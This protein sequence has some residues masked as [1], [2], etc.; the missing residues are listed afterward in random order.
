MTKG[1][2]SA[3]SK[4]QN[5][6]F[7]HRL[8]FDDN[9][10]ARLVCC[11]RG[12]LPPRRAARFVEEIVRHAPFFAAGVAEEFGRGHKEKPPAV[13]PG[14]GI[15]GAVRGGKDREDFGAAVVE[16]GEPRV[17]RFFIMRAPGSRPY[18]WR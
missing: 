10:S 1:G 2:H 3:F 17:G 11:R 6:S 18:F 14:F 4:K 16:M 13:E 9:E 8:I 7:F 5:V 12:P 15:R